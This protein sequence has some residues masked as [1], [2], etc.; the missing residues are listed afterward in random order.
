MK[1]LRNWY[2]GTW[3]QPHNPANS[4]LVFGPYQEHHWTAQIVRSVVG[5]CQRHWQWIVGT[6]IALAALYVSVLS[7]K[8]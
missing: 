3:T 7:L 2:E 1:W 6:A 8:P 5:F 4:Y